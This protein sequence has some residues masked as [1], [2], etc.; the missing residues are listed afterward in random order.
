MPGGVNIVAQ[1]VRGLS[2][3]SMFLQPRPVWVLR[4]GFE[5]IA[6]S[7]FRKQREIVIPSEQCLDAVRDTDCRYAGIVADT[8]DKMSKGVAASSN[9]C[10]RLSFTIAIQNSDGYAL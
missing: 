8:A 9:R 1:V 4:S 10:P 2:D 3:E 7:Q 5:W 6:C